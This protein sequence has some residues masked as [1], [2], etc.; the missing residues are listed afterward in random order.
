MFRAESSPVLDTLPLFDLTRGTALAETSIR[1]IRWS[2]VH[3]FEAA[4]LL[5]IINN[6]SEERL[7][8]IILRRE[9]GRRTCLPSATLVIL[10]LKA[11]GPHSMT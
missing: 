7:T 1:G 11:N 8:V 6:V 3:K 9:G 5:G 2:G 4:A 10:K